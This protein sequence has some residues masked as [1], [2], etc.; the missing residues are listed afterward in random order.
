LKCNKLIRQKSKSNDEFED[1]CLVTQTYP[2]TDLDMQ[3]QLAADV[4]LKGFRNSRIAYDVLNRGPTSL[5]E[6][7]ELSL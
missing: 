4:F 1:V 3:D 5:N 2:G 6:A 7:I